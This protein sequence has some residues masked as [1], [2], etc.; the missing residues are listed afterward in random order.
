MITKSQVSALLEAYYKA[1]PSPIGL[2]WPQLW[3]QNWLIPIFW[4]G[5]KLASTK[6]FGSNLYLYFLYIF[7]V[8]I[9]LFSMPLNNFWWLNWWLM[10]ITE[11]SYRRM[12]CCSRSQMPLIKLNVWNFKWQIWPQCSRKGWYRICS[13]KGNLGLIGVDR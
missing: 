1:W 13:G 8:F 10:N 12:Q 6:K 2:A 5:L 4:P 3:P 11:S 7:D 9:D